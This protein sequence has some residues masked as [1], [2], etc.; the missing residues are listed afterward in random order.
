MAGIPLPAL[1]IKQQQSD[2]LESYGRLVQLQSLLQQ[3]KYNQQAQPLKIQEAQQQLQSGELENQQ[4]AMQLKD[5]QTVMQVLSQNQGDLD[6]SLPQL[7]GKVSPQTFM[8]LAKAHLDMRK[9]VAELNEKELANQKQS[10]DSLLGLIEQ[11][12]QLPPDQY[13][14]QWPNIAQQALQINPKLQ[15]HI[16]PAQPVPQEALGQYEIGLQTQSVAQAQELK[17]REV[18]AQETTAQAHATQA[19]RPTETSLAL[20][21]TQGDRARKQH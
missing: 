7:A 19:A 8:G 6:R 13:A 5:Q 17:K 4:K 2:P 20:A 12:K 10:N 18:A 16:D 14:Q 15:G 1:D 11:A 21:A 3:Q 9:S